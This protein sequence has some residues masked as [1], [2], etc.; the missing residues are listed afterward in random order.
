MNLRLYI[1][2]AWRNVLRNKRRTLIAG[3]AVA[4]GLGALIFIDALHIGMKESMISSATDSFMGEGQILHEEY[5]RSLEVEHTVRNLPLVIDKLENEPTVAHYTLRTMALG[6]LSSPANVASVQMV[7]VDPETE[8]ALSEID[9]V[10]VEGSYFGDDSEFEI[11]IGSKLADLL[12]VGLGDRVVM[13]AAEAH[14]GDLAQEMFR[15]SGI[16]RFNVQ[17]M[18]QSM[19]FVRIERA[20]QMLGLPDQVHQIAL[21]FTDREIGRQNNAPIWDRLATEGNEAVGWT[22][23]MPQLEKVFDL[24]RIA[25]VIIAVIVFG[26]VALGIINTLFMSLYERMFEFG[27][28][29]AVGTRP[30]AMG[31][32]VI[33]EALALGL[34]AVVLGAVL[35]FLITFITTQTGID[36]AG[37]EYE[38]VTF[39]KLLT[40]VMHV[41]Q[42]VLYPA[43]LM[44]FTALIALYPAA[45]AARLRPAEAMRKSF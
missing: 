17:E 20:Q 40:P 23:L 45:Y 1:K 10:M 32:L 22:T 44:V 14:T 43:A 41:Q 25:R 31:R 26:V 29:R 28:M 36:F 8:P 33:L 16:Y 19:A 39:R 3:T 21:K 6:M 12:E 4:I 27:V 34:I 35:G 15:I 13:T 37:I 11:L 5:R 7:G 18:D 42:Y 9:E 2:L 24:S 38:G 30:L